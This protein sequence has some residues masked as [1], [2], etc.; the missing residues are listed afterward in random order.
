MRFTPHTSHLTPHTSHFT[1]HTW[2]TGEER[3][4]LIGI[5]PRR[6]GSRKKRNLRTAVTCE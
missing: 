5:R 3:M 2:V 1:P 6:R 4:A